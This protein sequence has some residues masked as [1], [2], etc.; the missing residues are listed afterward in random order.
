MKQYKTYMDKQKISQETHRK[1]L[2]LDRPT[3]RKRVMGAWVGVAALA[4]CCLLVVGIW[5]LAPLQ[6]GQRGSA[7]EMSSGSLFLDSSQESESFLIAGADG[8]KLMFPLIPYIN[9]QQVDGRQEV[10]AQIATPAGS[11]DVELTWEDIQTM[12]WG[13]EGKPDPDHFK[14]EQGSL[15]WM[16]FWTDYQ[17]HGRVIYDGGGTLFWLMLFGEH[18]DGSSFELQLALDHLP[19]ACLNEPGLETTDVNG[20][21]VTGWSRVY[22]RNGDSITD[23]ICGS[24][25]MAGE[26]GVRF[27]NVG[28]PFQEDGDMALDGAAQFNALFVRQVLS[29]D[30]GLYLDHLRTTED[31]PEWRDA[32]FSTLAQAREESA[33]AP[34]LPEESVTGYG[35]CYG[36]MTYQEGHQNT[37]FVRWSRG[38]D[39][40]EVSVYLPEGE[41]WWGDTADVTNPASYDTRLYEIPWT[42]SVPE[43]YRGTFYTP[44]FRAEDM[45]LAVVEARGTEKDT[46][47]MVYRFGV[48]H[49][50]GVLVKYSCSGLTAPQ[51]W[52]LVEDTL[53]DNF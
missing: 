45:S 29:E 2:E 48:L 41:V 8:E 49:P 18:P 30:G 13:P 19:P 31:I 11:F 16:L 35:E 28:S 40:V 12:F 17:V 6:P 15:P 47:G 4:A 7:P 51:V 22:D 24:E 21:A 1:L 39:D 27:E 25:F 9:Y 26:V 10:A 14:T 36:H 46:G 34:Y 37:L 20:T 44:D 23:Y 43:E 33:F 3:R 42:D 52:K 50:D 38:Y 5:K 53:D 32:E